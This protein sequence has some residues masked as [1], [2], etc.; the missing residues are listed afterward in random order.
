MSGPEADEQPYNHANAAD[1]F[2][3]RLI[4]PLERD[5]PFL[6][7]ALHQFFPLGHCPFELL[8]GLSRGEVPF[9]EA[10][11]VGSPAVFDALEDRLA[12]EAY[13]F[14]PNCLCVTT[15]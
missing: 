4:C 12:V 1:S 9:L 13:R 2:G 15:L 5:L 14:L 3:P 8:D 11:V 7:D 6:R 10:V